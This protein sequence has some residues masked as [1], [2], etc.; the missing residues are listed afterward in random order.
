MGGY[1]ILDTE[2]GDMI[3]YD[4]VKS[5][6]IKGASV[7]GEFLLRFYKQDFNKEDII[8]EEIFKILNQVD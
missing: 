8:L 6:K 7:E 3:W 1:K 2:E 4:Y 5:G